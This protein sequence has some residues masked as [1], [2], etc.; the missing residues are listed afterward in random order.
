MKWWGWLAIAIVGTIMWGA[1]AVIL[2]RV[3]W[4][5]RSEYG[6]FETLLA[7]AVL[8]WGCCIVIPVVQKAIKAAKGDK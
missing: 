7:G 3:G 6:R 4:F 5:P 8:I 1:V 2:W